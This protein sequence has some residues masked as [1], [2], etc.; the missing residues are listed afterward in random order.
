M[1]ELNICLKGHEHEIYSLMSNLF[2]RVL[3]CTIIFLSLI[4]W[5][6]F[7]LPFKF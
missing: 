6:D 5:A 7:I 2:Y 3:Q 1:F 4:S